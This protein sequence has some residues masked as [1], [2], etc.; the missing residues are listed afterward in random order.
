MKFVNTVPSEAILHLH[1][2]ICY[3][4][5]TNMAAARTCEMEITILSLNVGWIL[6]ICA[7]NGL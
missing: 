4:N 7:E 3:S 1:V 6:I 2:L 5:N